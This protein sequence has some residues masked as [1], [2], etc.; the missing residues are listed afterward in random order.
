MRDEE[1]VILYI[2]VVVSGFNLSI[3]LLCSHF[4]KEQRQVPFLYK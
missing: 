1:Q 4:V 3:D 2:F